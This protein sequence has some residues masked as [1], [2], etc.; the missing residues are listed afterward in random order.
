M[1][2][3]KLAQAGRK[4]IEIQSA[5]SHRMETALEG[6]GQLPQW[7][8]RNGSDEIVEK[9]M[10]RLDEQDAEIRRRIRDDVA[11]GFVL[12]MCT[13]LET[14]RDPLTKFPEVRHDPE[15]HEWI[16]DER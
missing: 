6:D 4:L 11:E 12:D 13:A 3:A 8:M 10:P 1:K 15:G 7:H 5:S 14:Q 16:G 9:L 2:Q